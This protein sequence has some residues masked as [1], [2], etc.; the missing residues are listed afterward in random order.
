MSIS[1]L[2]NK[3]KDIESSIDSVQASV[4]GGKGAAIREQLETIRG[5]SQEFQQ[6]H[7]GLMQ[8]IQSKCQNVIERSQATIKKAK[9]MKEA[10]KKMP[11]PPKPGFVFPPPKKELPMEVDPELGDRLRD[12]LLSRFG[13]RPKSNGVDGLDWKDWLADHQ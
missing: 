8:S 13:L 9:E 12:Q 10:A 5:S 7:Q 6:L 1:E 2:G 4:G 3:I 11:P